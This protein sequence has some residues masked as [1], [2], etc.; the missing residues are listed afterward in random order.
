MYNHFLQTA[1][2]PSGLTPLAYPPALFAAAGN[3]NSTA[4]AAS[5]MQQLQHQGQQT[6]LI[7]VPAAGL[8][9]LSSQHHQQHQLAAATAGGS[10]IYS[11]SPTTTTAFHH[12]SASSAFAQHAATFGGVS[13]GLLAGAPAGA[14]GS[15]LTAAAGGFPTGTSRG[16]TGGPLQ[17]V[18]AAAAA[19]AAVAVTPNPAAAAPN[20]HHQALQQQYFSMQFVDQHQQQQQQLLGYSGNWQQQEQQQQQQQRQVRRNQQ[21][22]RPQPQQQQSAV[23]LQ[24]QQQCFMDPSQQPA[25][26]QPSLQHQLQARYQQVINPQQQSGRVQQLAL[27]SMQQPQPPSTP[28]QDSQQGQ[29][30][31]PQAQLLYDYGGSRP[32]QQA[33][34]QPQQVRRVPQQHQQVPEQQVQPPRQLLQLLQHQQH[35]QQLMRT[36]PHQPGPQPAATPQKQQM[37]RFPAAAGAGG[38]KPLAAAAAAGPPAASP[39][40]STRASPAGTS[41]PSV[42]PPPARATGGPGG[43]GRSVAAAAVPPQHQQQQHR[44]Q[45]QE[46]P[47]PPPDAD[48]DGV[49][50]PTPLSLPRA[51]IDW[52]A[53][54]TAAIAPYEVLPPGHP[55]K[56]LDGLQ[57]L[58][59]GAVEVL[60]AETPEA[61]NAAVEVLRS[62]MWDGVVAMDME[63][64]PD[65]S[66]GQSNPVALLQLS[67][68]GLVV[69]VRTLVC[70]LPDAFRTGFMEDSDV[71][72]VVAGWGTNDERKFEESFGL[73]TFWCKITDIQKIAKACGHSKTGVR[74]LVQAVLE[75]SVGM[76]KS[77]KTTMSNWGAP[78]LQ[79]EQLKYAVLDA[80]CTEHVFRC[81]EGRF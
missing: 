13:V 9:G 45:Q 6:G 81:L 59:L 52:R 1:A 73:T 51:I 42:A 15:P 60:L 54:F 69:L 11:G 70:G 57:E 30:G 62:R 5:L 55:A 74:A 12:L 32:L 24:A 34:P 8:V 48:D 47:P 72:L 20:V 37:P 53:I 31:Q 44:R 43:T 63:W 56:G 14:R 41:P 46:P 67:S 10:N 71:E 65:T 26:L 22:P 49:A 80:A 28:Q 2:G 50:Q 78:S 39:N 79:A 21:Q 7:P 19:A 38:S 68:C 18:P 64:K 17:L 23:Q 33:Q 16:A 35:Q 27:V 61:A 58:R 77:K 76:P 36:S 40:D 66:R 75:P 29:Q 25:L 3:E 4:A